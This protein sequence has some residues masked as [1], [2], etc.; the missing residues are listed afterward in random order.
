MSIVKIN[1][2]D[3]FG[4]Y[5]IICRDSTKQTAAIYWIC[6]CLYCK[7]QKSIRST[8][9]RKNPVCHCQKGKENI[10]KVFDEWEI[11]S[12]LK[13]RGKDKSILYD[14]KCL[15]C[16]HHEKIA[17]NVLKLSRKHCP[18]CYQKKSTLIDMTG[19]IYG[20]L[21]VLERDLSEKHTGMKQILIGCVNVYYAELK[22]LFV[23]LV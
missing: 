2:N 18:N 3:I 16:G 1:P 17:M 15:Y 23:G 4:S 19:K 7:E 9:V 20:N 11:M 22:K 21:K 5:K 8:T 13:D 12:Q 10:G 14:C 6:E